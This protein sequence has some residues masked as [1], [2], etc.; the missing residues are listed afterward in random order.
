METGKGQYIKNL[1]KAFKHINVHFLN[2]RYPEARSLKRK[3]IFHCGPTNSGKTFHAI[4]KFL[5]SNTGIYCGPLKL[6][7]VEI[8]NKSNESGTKCDLVTGEEIIYSGSDGD[9]TNHV[10]CTVEMCSLENTCQYLQIKY[11]STVF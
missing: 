7:A 3:I 4:K 11:I 9:H 5:Q 10:S 8:F 1:A 6:L 2:D